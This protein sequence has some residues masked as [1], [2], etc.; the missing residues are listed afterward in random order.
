M[1]ASGNNSGGGGS[2][3]IGNGNIVSGAG[4]HAVGPGGSI[5]IVNNYAAASAPTPTPPPLD[6]PVAPLVATPAEVFISYSRVDRSLV[7]PLIARLRELVVTWWIDDY[8]APGEPF[9]RRI[10]LQVNSC[11]AHIVAWSP[12][13]VE[14]DWVRSEADKGRHRGTL[15][16]ILLEPC[17]IPMPFGQ[18]HTTDVSHWSGQHADTAWRSVL[19]V[20]AHKLARPGLQELA[21]LVQ[22]RDGPGVREWATRYPDDPF[23]IKKLC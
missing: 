10:D 21:A 3:V 15:V 16:P 2:F 1:T 19:N 6:P 12:Q 22:V 14:S 11:R 17:S 4:A 7:E 8:L 9:D 5:S 13:S 18:I 23:V 20:L